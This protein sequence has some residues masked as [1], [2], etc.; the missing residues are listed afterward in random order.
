MQ[1]FWSTWVSYT[2]YALFAISMAMMG[3]GFFLTCYSWT[4]KINFFSNV[5]YTLV[6]ETRIP[7]GS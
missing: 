3:F 2:K 4:L 1:N 5:A 6:S 7:L